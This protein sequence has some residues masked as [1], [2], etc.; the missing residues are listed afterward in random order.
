MRLFLRIL[1]KIGVE[2]F[3]V[4]K[5]VERVFWRDGRAVY[6][7]C[8]ENNWVN[9]P[10][11]SNPSPSAKGNG[12]FLFWY[13][14]GYTRAQLYVSDPGPRLHNTVDNVRQRAKRFVGER[15]VVCIMFIVASGLQSDVDCNKQTGRR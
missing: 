7:D 12:A 1:F 9:S 6:G 15:F 10:G 14:S 4:N 5:P 2:E 13:L 3:T 11:G 8:L